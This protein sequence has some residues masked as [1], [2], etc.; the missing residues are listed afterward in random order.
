M[1][2]LK[3]RYSISQYIKTIAILSATYLLSMSMIIGVKQALANNF[4]F[5]FY[6]SLVGIILG[7]LLILTVTVWQSSVLITIDNETLDIHLPNQKI[8][9]S[10]TW[11]EV[12]MIGIG[13][14]HITIDGNN[15]NY[16]I[17]FGNLKYNDL[18][19]IKTKLIE[20]CESK[21]IPFKNI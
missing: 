9:G 11:S 19:K 10:I 21:D 2:E 8:D 13:I 14:A 5:V 3:I 15:D 12:T 6:A 18:K 7:I 17:D 20:I 16:K 1:N 4:A